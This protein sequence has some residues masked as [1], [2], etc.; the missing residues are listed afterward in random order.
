MLINCLFIGEGRPRDDDKKEGRGRGRG[1]GAIR[2][3]KPSYVIMKK[4]EEQ[5]QPVSFV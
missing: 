1:R 4:P 3:E 2:P 5:K